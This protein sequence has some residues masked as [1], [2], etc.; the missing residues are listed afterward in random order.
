MR[1]NMLGVDEPI[2]SPTL[3]IINSP[4]LEPFPSLCLEPASQSQQGQ[5]RTPKSTEDAGNTSIR[6][7]K[8]KKA[9]L[10]ARER[11]RRYMESL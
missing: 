2:V 7:E 5:E 1:H 10:Q 9:G 6:D 11:K 3:F 8:K 4:D